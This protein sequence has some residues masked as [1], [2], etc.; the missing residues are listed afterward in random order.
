MCY[1]G[2]MYVIV[3]CDVQGEFIF[4]FMEA[5]GISADSVGEI[6]AALLLALEVSFS[7]Y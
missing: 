7:H 2:Y 5:A 6:E 1:H 3:L 4:E